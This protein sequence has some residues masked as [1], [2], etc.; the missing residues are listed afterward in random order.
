MD[1]ERWRRGGRGGDGMMACGVGEWGVGLKNSDMV[2]KGVGVEVCW[3]Y[4]DGYGCDRV[5]QLV[6]RKDDNG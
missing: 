6:G 3:G 4:G 1:D 5:A 2:R